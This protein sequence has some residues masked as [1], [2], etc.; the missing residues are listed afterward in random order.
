MST[1]I[2][3]SQSQLNAHRRAGISSLQSSDKEREGSAGKGG[4]AASLPIISI[5]L[6]PRSS[7]LGPVL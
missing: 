2:L 7:V 5:S 3:P 4:V 1:I 6:L